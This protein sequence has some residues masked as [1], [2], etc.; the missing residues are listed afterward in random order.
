[1][2]DTKS[3]TTWPRLQLDY[4]EAGALVTPDP[5]LPI[6]STPDAAASAP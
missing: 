5:A 1:V 3:G 6:G 2:A 4:V